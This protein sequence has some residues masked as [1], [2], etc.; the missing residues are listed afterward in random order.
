[1]QNKA[2]VMTFEIAKEEIKVYLHRDLRM[3][4]SLHSFGHKATRI[5]YSNSEIIMSLQSASLYEEPPFTDECVP[6]DFCD[7][8]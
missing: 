4:L 1:M 8:V 2:K 7:N 6:V 3:I 5:P